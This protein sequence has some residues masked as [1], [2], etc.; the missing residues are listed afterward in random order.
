[1]NYSASYGFTCENFTP[2]MGDFRSI[3]GRV[4][5]FK[6]LIQKIL[7]LPFVLLLK[8]GVTLARGIGVVV[9]FILL[10]VTFGTSHGACE[11]FFRRVVFLARDLAEWVLFPFSAILGFFRL[12]LGGIVHPALYFR[13]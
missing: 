13:F 3:R 2:E 7:Q 9:A 8:G 5:C 12:L 6:T 11:F 10:V 1:M 4:L